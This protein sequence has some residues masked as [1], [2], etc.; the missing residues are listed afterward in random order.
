[1]GLAIGQF[2]PKKFGVSVNDSEC[3]PNPTPTT[4]VNRLENIRQIFLDLLRQLSK[5]S[6]GGID[7]NIIGLRN[8]VPEN[9]SKILFCSHPF[10][11]HFRTHS[12]PTTIASGTDSWV[13][14]Q[15]IAVKGS[16]F[17]RLPLECNLP[18]SF[19]LGVWELIRCVASS[20][21][22]KGRAWGAREAQES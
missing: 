12:T 17:A 16:C 15:T 19:S 18:R 4:T 8:S 10:L 2:H 22:T 21:C 14:T 9:A 3:L 11:H 5:F 6:P 13:P 20:A 1:M 7:I